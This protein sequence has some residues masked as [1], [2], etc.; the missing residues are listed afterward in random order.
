MATITN[1][2]R[3]A[4]T[5]IFSMVYVV[6]KFFANRAV[7]KQTVRELNTLNDRELEDLGLCRADIPDVARK[8]VAAR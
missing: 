4:P 7:Y 6:E 3:F 2:T 8:T 1:T 5:G